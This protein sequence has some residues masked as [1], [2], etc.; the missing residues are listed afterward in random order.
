M[1]VNND[2]IL[3]DINKNRYPVYLSDILREHP[4]VSFPYEPDSKILKDFGYEVVERSE[5]P[6]GPVVTESFPE[7]TGEVWIQTWQVREFSEDELSS[8]L[9][10]RKDAL[11]SKLSEMLELV[12][13]G[14]YGFDKGGQTYHAQYRSCDRT[15][16][17][18]LVEAARSKFE[19]GDESTFQF[20]TKENIM[21]SLTAVDF[22]DI[23]S[24][25]LS[26]ADIIQQ[27]YWTIKDKIAAAGSVSELPDLPQTLA[28]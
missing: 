20:R 25:L 8:Q 22:L 1:N 18:L 21:V 17:S 14:G 26:W 28:E 13:A 11:N 6:Q 7:K 16:L 19:I 27:K 24:K 2:T 15:N 23:V 3:I 5:P 4:N 12:Y 10:G 9:Q